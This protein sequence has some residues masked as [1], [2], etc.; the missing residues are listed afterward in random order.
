[1]EWV[2]FKSVEKVFE[3]EELYWYLVCLFLDFYVIL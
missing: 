2:T 3:K 1:M